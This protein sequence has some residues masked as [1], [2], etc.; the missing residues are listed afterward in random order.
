MN[1]GDCVQTTDAWTR[2]NLGAGSPSRPR[3]RISGVI[4]KIGDR[5][6]INSKR[7]V[8]IKLDE[9]FLGKWGY[10]WFDPTELEAIDA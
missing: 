5:G 2:D 4:S 10:L 3:R 9:P 6:P 7:T 1:V 8:Q